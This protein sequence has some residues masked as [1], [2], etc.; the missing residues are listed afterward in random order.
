MEVVCRGL[1]S[2]SDCSI[3]EVVLTF[4]F[5]GFCIISVLRGF[6]S[7]HGWGLC[8]LMVLLMLTHGFRGPTRDALLSPLHSSECENEAFST[9]S[10][11]PQDRGGRGGGG[12]EEGRRAAI[13][14]YPLTH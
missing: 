6:S 13:I 2:R 5:L 8:L 9:D 14:L 7:V 11:N 10:W 1:S 12:P 4:Y 3:G